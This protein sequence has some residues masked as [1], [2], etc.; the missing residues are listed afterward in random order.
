M[1]ANCCV[2]ADQHPIEYE[3][4]EVPKAEVYSTYESWAEKHGVEKVTKSRFTRYL[5][6]C[7]T[8]ETDRRC[9]DGEIVRNFVGFTLD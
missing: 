2:F 6:E 5:T 9:E 8:F 4:A 3:E 7:I 1:T